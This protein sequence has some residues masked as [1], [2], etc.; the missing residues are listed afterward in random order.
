MKTITNLF[1]TAVLSLTGIHSALAEDGGAL[2]AENFS[3]TLTLTSSY[4]Y[5]GI[6]FSDDNV[7]LQG[8]FD[9]GYGN[10]F[11]GI[12]SSSIVDQD[13]GVGPHP[14]GFG[15]PGS[16]YELE[17]D[18]YVGYADS[19][20]GFDWYVMPIYYHFW[21][22]DKDNSVVPN[23]DADV[24]EVW[25]DVSRAINDTISV[26]ALYAYSPDFF[27]ESGDA[28]YIKGDITVALPGDF[29]INGGVGV[30]TVDGGKAPGLTS[31]WTYTHWEIGL[32]KSLVGFD[33]DLRYHGTSDDEATDDLVA[34]FTGATDITD[35]T[36]V[37]TISRSF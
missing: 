11:A 17:S 13:P 27:F 33:F 24:F 36:I 8:S 20:A 22:F 32:S 2:A 4:M 12:W 7:A 5:R 16:E 34:V 23:A 26:H 6:S 37:F 35:D 9:W 29:S 10:F 19:I 28:H 21:G 14:D 31:G 15:G 18:F 1:L 25:F 3:A 30:Q